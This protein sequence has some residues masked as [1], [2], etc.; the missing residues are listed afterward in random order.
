MTAL[1][2]E[3]PPELNGAGYCRPN[4]Q[5][6]HALLNAAPEGT[7]WVIDTETTGLEVRGPGAKDTAVWVGLLPLNG[8]IAVILDRGIFDLVRDRIA[9]LQLIGHN[10]RFDLHALDFH[11]KKPPIDTMAAP[12]F[13]N[14]AASKSLDFLAAKRGYP[15]LAT[16]H[17]LKTGQ[18]EKLPFETLAA[19]LADDVLFTE[20]LYREQ[21]KFIRHFKL[22]D[23]F[24]LERAV[25]NME[26]RGVILDEQRLRAARNLAKTDI[27]AAKLRLTSMGF[28]ATANIDSPTQIAAWLIENGR[29]LPL[30]PSGKPKCDKFVLQD[31]ADKGDTFAEVLINYRRLTKLDSAFLSKLPEHARNGRIYPSINTMLTRT[32]R[33]SYSDPNLQ[34]IPKGR[35]LPLAKEIRQCL[36]GEGGVSVADYSQVELRVAAALSKEPVLLEAFAAGRDVH[37]EVAAKMLGKSPDQVSDVE[38]FGAKAVNFGI[39]NGMGASRLAVELKSSVA[40]AAGFLEE[41]RSAMPALTQW[42]FDLWERAETD[43]IAY[44]CSGRTRI[45]G[46]GESTRP[47]V[48]VLVQG[49]AAELMRAAIVFADES[50]L[51]PILAVHDELVIEGQGH[52]RELAEAMRYAAESRFPEALY[53]VS[54]PADGFSALT[55]GG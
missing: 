26:Q 55:W 21:E 51:R 9:E 10:V 23:D 36:T 29:R 2:I 28:P 33:F 34:Q 3:R 44:T 38:R 5:Q 8:S 18:I 42:M 50:R 49:T 16:P 37:R 20:R 52:E 6:L 4:P 31:L 25:F 48:S 1:V 19:Y 35:N 32:G 40:H 11:P 45:F 24:A 54:F 15:K 30:T 53:G 13:G 22:E 7:P 12:Y 43:R 17:E 27:A 46:E 41:Y 47:A 14:M 39:L